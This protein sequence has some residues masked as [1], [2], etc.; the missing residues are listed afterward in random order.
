MICV[1]NVV[2]RSCACVCSRSRSCGRNAEEVVAEV[3]L[4]VT[5]NDYIRSTIPCLVRQNSGDVCSNG[6]KNMKLSERLCLLYR[7][8][9]PRLLFSIRDGNIEYHFPEQFPNLHGV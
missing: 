1:E 8:H 7:M 9:L 5:S 6:K 4:V 2:D 3:E